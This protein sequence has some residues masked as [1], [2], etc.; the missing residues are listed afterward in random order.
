V[1]TGLRLPTPLH[2]SPAAVTVID[3]DQ[4]A[5]APQVA[6]DDLVRMAP[7]VGTFRRSSSAI[8][9]P[10]S[11][12]LNLRGVGPSGVSRALALRDGLPLNDPFG[13]WVY[14]RAISP[15]EL[16]QIELVP[17]GASALFGNFALGGALQMISRPITGPSAGPS[18]DV[19]IAGGSLDSDRIAL[20]A[21][22]QRGDFAVALSAQAM[23][24]AGYTPI[25]P[26]ER[27]PVDGPAPSSDESG[28]ARVEYRHG[29]A[30][31]HGEVRAFHE[32]LDAGTE[33]TTAEVR[34]LTYDAGGER[35]L[36]PGA[37]VAQVFGGQ[38]RF[39]Q[40]RARVQPDRV[41]AASAGTQRTPS[42]N[43]GAAV[44]WTARVADRHAIVAG[45]D[46]QRVAGTATD[47]LTPAAVTATTLVERRAGGEQR[48]AGAFVED[49]VHVVPA[50]EVA[51]A[52][53]L[54]GWQNLD[55]RGTLGRGDGS[56]TTTP[57]AQASELQL[58]PRLGA[59]VH[60][61][62]EFAVRGSAY[63]GFRA[64][65]LNELYRPFQVGSV[66]TAAND[67]LRPETL[68]G[69]ELGTEVGTPHLRMVATA[70][71]NRLYDPISNVTLSEPLDGATRQRQNL[72]RAR[73]FGIDLDLAWRPSPAWTVRVAH[74]FSDAHVT[75]A[76]AQPMLVGKQLA[77][78]PANRTTASLTF[79]DERIATVVG[80]VRYLDRMFEDD[81]NTLPIGAVVVFDARVERRLGPG[82]A[83]FLT[84][85]NLTNRQ[86]VVGRAGLD[87]LGAPRTFEFGLAYHA[88]DR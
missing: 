41:A 79:H 13:G 32:S 85:Q 2:D 63:R 3:R 87:T 30:T 76:P 8:A 65:T 55:A 20:R 45:T 84:G 44:S 5:Q 68:W 53:R 19:V 33:F 56:T 4:M 14:W 80:E 6:A 9:D 42:N 25:A 74:T 81:L 40:E 69:G 38:Q 82:F 35:A 75:D 64:P 37:L 17:S 72:G 58:D 61:S 29:G 18:I 71:W 10:T 88:G 47:L 24:T 54:D 48:F 50:L 77:Q 49:T 1:V 26:A 12:G 78:D 28:A 23:H 46:A 21:T 43:Q 31:L 16:A 67:R 86:Y 60:V 59:L 39:D 27:G 51:G 15:L 7:D 70:F 62:S 11:Q 34:T 83:L 57:F 36:G 66:L 22:E 52:L 73:I